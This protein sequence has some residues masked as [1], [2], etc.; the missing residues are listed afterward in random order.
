MNSF[1]SLRENIHQELTNLKSQKSL[2]ETEISRLC[3][4]HN[5][6]HLSKDFDHFVE[7]SK[8]VILPLLFVLIFT[9]VKL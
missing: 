1:A 3:K 7:R 9:I 6:E 5:T 2:L 8:Y 4:Q